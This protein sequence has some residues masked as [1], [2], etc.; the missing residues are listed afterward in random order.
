MCVFPPYC[1]SIAIVVGFYLVTSST[2]KFMAQ[3]S[4]DHM[5]WMRLIRVLQAA[6]KKLNLT[7]KLLNELHEKPDEPESTNRHS[8][9]EEEDDAFCQVF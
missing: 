6:H 7:E 5:K 1:L 2:S 4:P 9:N 8:S 3:Y